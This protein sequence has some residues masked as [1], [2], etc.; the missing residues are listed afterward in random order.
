[1]SRSTPT[2]LV[3]RVALTRTE[4][5]YA[6]GMSVDFFDDHVAHE[7]SAVRRGRL[8]FFPLAELERWADESAQQIRVTRQ[9]RTV[10]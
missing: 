10:A 7:L 9:A 4:A 5:A 3:P 1:M 6:L 2:R 8:R